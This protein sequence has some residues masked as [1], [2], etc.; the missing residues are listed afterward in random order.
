MSSPRVYVEPGTDLA[1]DRPS[2]SAPAPHTVERLLDHCAEWAQEV[3]WTITSDVAEAD[4]AVVGPG[5]AAPAGLRVVRVERPQGI[6]GFRWGIRALAFVRRWPA[7]TVTY[8]QLSDQVMEVRRPRGARRGVV[9]LIHGGFWMQDWRRGLM[10]G[11]AV[12]LV[13]R[14]W[15]SW[16][17]E[18]GRVGGSGGWPQTG[19]DVLS[20]VDAVLRLAD[21]EQVVL[22]GHSA[23]GQ[24]AL[25]AAAR[26]REAVSRVVSLAGLCDLETALSQRLGGGAVERLLDGQPVASASPLSDVPIGVPVLLAHCA[27]DSVVPVGQS[28]R[29]AQVATAA[30]DDVELVV[31]DEGDHMALIEPESAWVGIAERL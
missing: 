22:V 20:A 5:V 30:G 23:G 18:Y 3:A 16:N 6:D 29:F 11:L 21:V 8:G 10:A 19:Q 28:E 4:A 9:V 15:E 25:H 12:D 24:L 2:L 13:E 7:E 17:I 26:R 31:L 1:L 27:G 14:G